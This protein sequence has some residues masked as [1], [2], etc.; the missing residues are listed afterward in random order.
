MAEDKNKKGQFNLDKSGRKFDLGKGESKKFDLN[1]SESK[2]F[3]LSKGDDVPTEMTASAQSPS[4]TSKL[5][6]EDKPDTAST[7]KAEHNPTG[8]QGSTTPPASGDEDNGNYSGKRKW[9]VAAI[10]VAV[11]IFA[12][13]WYANRDK[14]A[15]GD[16]FATEQPTAAAD[17]MGTANDSIGNTSDLAANPDATSE[18][19]TASSSEPQSS[20]PKVADDTQAATADNSA[21]VATHNSEPQTASSESKTE[22]GIQ[23]PQAIPVSVDQAAQE[24]LKGKYGNNPERRRLLGGRYKEIQRA[25]NQL[26]REGKVR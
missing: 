13:V 1:K 6:S 20:Q 10:I 9:I 17:S 25:V 22:S 11:L 7:P 4:P 18:S 21:P 24:V 12:G 19:A 26:Y 14:G 5:A 15:K 2:K 8:N 16:S 23:S 3:D